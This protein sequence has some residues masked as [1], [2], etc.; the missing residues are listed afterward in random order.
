[1]KFISKEKKEIFNGKTCLLRLDL[2]VQNNELNNSIRI[3]RSIETIKFLLNRG[4]KVI[5]V[6]HRGRPNSNLKLKTQKSKQERISVEKDI[7]LRSFMRIFKRALKVGVYFDDS[8]NFVKIKERVSNLPQKSVTIL[9]NIRL[10]KGEE[11]NDSK[12]G[13]ALASLAD[14]Y[15]NDA[16]AVSHRSNA[17]VCAITK[18]IKSYAGL[19]FEK[20]IEAFKTINNPSHPFVV[21]LGG[22]KI[23]DKIGVIDSF[24]KKADYILVGGGVAN[25]FFASK[26]IPIGDSLFEKNMTKKISRYGDSE[27]IVLPIDVKIENKKILD[28]GEKTAIKYSKLIKSAKMILWNGPMGIEEK[29]FENGTLSIVKAISDSRAYSV[30]G[31]GQTTSF[32]LKK[33]YENKISF[34]STGGGAMLEYLSG[35]KLPGIIALK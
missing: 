12:L 11:D 26:D 22:A 29:K 30:V 5:V 17:S 6:S 25:T 13:K 20:E 9:E 4:S 34:L 1:M 33:G 21:I 35:K 14:F 2:N 7:T 8:F 10:I 27:K 32:V 18:Y 23:S 31:G 15:V 16:F 19:E 3:K 24:Y 28:I